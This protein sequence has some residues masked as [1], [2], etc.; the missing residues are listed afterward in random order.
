MGKERAVKKI[1]ALTVLA[2]AFSTL[3]TA[4]EVDQ[5][6]LQN[7]HRSGKAFEEALANPASTSAEI[8]ELCRRVD[9]EAQKVEH[10]ITT[11]QEKYIYDLYSTAAAEYVASI[12]R[13]EKDRSPTRLDVDLM[14]VREYLRIADDTFNG[15]PQAPKP[16]P[17]A[18]IPAVPEPPS[19]A[20]APAPRLESPA[21][22]AATPAS[23]APALPP[24]PP[25]SPP[26]TPP[27]A[28]LSIDTAPAPAAA[29]E[30][31]AT[32]P[33]SS[34]PTP[35]SALPPAPP[36][37]PRPTA[38]PRP[39][40]IVDASP[41]AI[42]KAADKVRVEKKEDAV[43]PCDLVGEISVAGKSVS[44]VYE[45]GGHNYY[46]GSGLELARFKTV[47]VGGDTILLKSSTK[48]ELLASAYR[49]AEFR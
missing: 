13:F 8:R 29:P 47:E 30:S 9:I 41:N 28:S 37:L 11:K 24:A 31:K 36:A 21:A 46:Y 3:L 22:G 35:P 7:L 43:R 45:I 33:V 20:A 26:A 14:P 12:Q 5:E 15:R 40:P 42:R 44:G 19:R 18:P 49:C 1:V 34:P 4:Q 16:P 2:A 32:E 27:T 48:T 6:K 17:P 38:A 23:P 39:R 10:G 25:V